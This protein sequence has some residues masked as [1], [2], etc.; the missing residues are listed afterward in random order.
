M[1]ASPRISWYLLLLLPWW[2]GAPRSG[3]WCLSLKPAPLGMGCFLLSLHKIVSQAFQAWC[4]LGLLEFNWWGEARTHQPGWALQGLCSG[5]LHGKRDSTVDA[6]SPDLLLPKQEGKIST[7]GCR[8]HWKSPSS[9]SAFW[10]KRAENCCEESPIVSVRLT[11]AL[12]KRK[13]LFSPGS[14][15]PGQTGKFPAAWLERPAGLLGEGGG[16]CGGG[17][18]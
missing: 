10:R 1:D 12:L 17:R 8:K 15:E 9:Y 11:E 18:G 4:T 6:L 13:H 14:R 3:F 7:P 2:A 5:P 16:G